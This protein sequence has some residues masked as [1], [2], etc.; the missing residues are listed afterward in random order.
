MFGLGNIYNRIT[1]KGYPVQIE[2]EKLFFGYGNL[3]AI[4]FD[5]INVIGEM[6]KR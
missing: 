6:K 3:P 4:S 5:E 2:Y 1:T